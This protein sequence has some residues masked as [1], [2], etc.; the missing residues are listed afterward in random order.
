M[1][2][3]RSG[4]WLDEEYPPLGATTIAK[5]VKPVISAPAAPPPAPAP[6]PAPPPASQTRA[7]LTPAEQYE[8]FGIDST[9]SFFQ[10]DFSRQDFTQA[11]AAAIPTIPDPPYDARESTD[12]SDLP[13]GFPESPNLKLFHPAALKKLD[14]E[15]LFYV[16]FFSP[17]TPQQ[18]FVA[19]ELKKRDWKFNTKYQ[20]WFKRA[21]EPTEKTDKHEVAS[22]NYFDTSDTVGGWCMRL[23]NAFKVEF[24]FLA[25]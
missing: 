6:T 16:F 7:A 8:L 10:T 22:F 11:V 20:T 9:D 18:Y 15:T 3:E 17:D 21:S 19:Q 4:T 13:P 1:S 5:P 14:L 24:E 12:S 25:D 23:R 2:H